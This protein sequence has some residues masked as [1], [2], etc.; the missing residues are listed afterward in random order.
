MFIIKKRKKTKTRI[1][2]IEKKFKPLLP[3]TSKEIKNLLYFYCRSKR[4]YIGV[5]SEYRNS[6]GYGYEE[7]DDFVAFNEKE[8]IA[9]E[10][11]ISRSDFLADFKKKKHDLLR[12][13]I[14]HRF[15]KKN[16]GLDYVPKGIYYH[17]FYFCVNE[18][19]RDFAEDYLNKNAKY[20]GLWVA[21]DN[22]IVAIKK[23]MLLKPKHYKDFCDYPLRDFI[24]KMGSELSYLKGELNEARITK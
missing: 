4:G 3:L 15:Y 21:V 24:A 23:P 5:M 2:F 12:E 19:L 11:K 1:M 14:N 20:A 13:V 16:K 17:K 18:D 22:N 6:F 8:I 9:V 10:I 7:I